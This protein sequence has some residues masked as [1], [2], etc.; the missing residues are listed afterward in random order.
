MSFPW[1]TV[2]MAVPLVGAGVVAALPRR[3]SDE[4]PK[5]VALVFSLVAL[6]LA[7]V[8]GIGY[9]VGRGFQYAEEVS[10]IAAFG[11]HYAL[12][13]DGIGLTLV[14]LTVIL[15]P[16]VILAS[17][18]DGDGGRWSVNSFFAWML[19]LEGLALGVFMATDVFLFYVLFEA[20]LIPIYF[21]IGGFGGIGRSYAA[22]KFLLYSLFGGLLMLA[23][24][25]GLYVV[26]ADS[27]AGPSFLLSDLSQI[28]MDQNVGRWLFLGF[29]I[30]FAIKAPMFPVHTWLPDAAAAGTPGTSVLLVSILDKIG[31]FGMIRFC[32]GLF[33]EASQ[34][35]TPVVLVLAVI[36]VLYGA[37]AAVG[38]NNI[39]R[40][41]AY[42]SVSH[43]GFIVMGIFVLNSYGQVGST[44]YMF[45]HGL[46]TA[47]LF[48]VTGFLIQ[49]RGSA[50]ISDFGGVEKVA[51]VMAGIFLVAGL[52]SLSLPGLSPFISEFLVLVGTFAYNW[53]YAVFAVLGIVLAALYIL[54]MYQRTMTGPTVPAVA[55]M[56]DLGLREVSALAPL[57]LLIV[58]LGFYPKPLTAIIDPAVQDTLQQ[59]GVSDPAP[60]VPATVGSGEEEESDQ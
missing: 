31:T 17:W 55:T 15:T 6:A 27:E 12:G 46:S 47:A 24:V 26:S 43:F 1:L 49:R 10:W 37:L 59:V 33:P 45:N 34:W 51:P 50:L 32:L 2:L 57:L 44:L 35:A 30:A 41:I 4:L 58:L 42:T 52:S 9:D 48:L 13:I 16:V 36:S 20:T 5:Q 28:A 60:E 22:I 54:L 7:A 11:A 14:L 53:W 25:I 18:N 40:L 23:S 3:T 56:K 39:S 19:A 21:L 29:F 8:I 38:Q